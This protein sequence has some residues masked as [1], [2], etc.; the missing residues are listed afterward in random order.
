MPDPGSAGPAGQLAAERIVW[1]AVSAVKANER[2]LPGPAGRKQGHPGAGAAIPGGEHPAASGEALLP[3]ERAGL[4]VIWE[5]ED[6]VA[7]ARVSA[8]TVLNLGVESGRNMRP[9][10]CVGSGVPFLK[11]GGYRPW[12]GY[13]AAK[14]V[15]HLLFG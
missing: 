13:K 7:G 15:P 8:Y 14:I 9:G 1:G 6:A 4:F 3:C 5:R 11:G 12:E 2:T 10:V